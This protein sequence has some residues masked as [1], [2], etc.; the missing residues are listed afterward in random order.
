MKHSINSLLNN[1]YC[2]HAAMTLSLLGFLAFT[3]CS[4]TGGIA[5]RQPLTKN[6]VE[7]YWQKTDEKAP[8]ANSDPNAEYEWFY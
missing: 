7:S 1:K 4:S 3:G 2:L 6:W 5:Q 8:A